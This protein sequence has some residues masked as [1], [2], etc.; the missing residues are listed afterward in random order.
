VIEVDQ[1]AIATQQT[2]IITN[3]HKQDAQLRPEPNKNTFALDAERIWEVTTPA[4]WDTDPTWFWDIPQVAEGSYTSPI[5]ELG[6]AGLNGFAVYVNTQIRT[7][8][9]WGWGGTM[10]GL[11]SDQYVPPGPPDRYPPLWS[12]PGMSWAQMAK[13]EV[14]IDIALSQDGTTFGPFFNVSSGVELSGKAFKVKL[15]LKQNLPLVPVEV[16]KCIVTVC[17]PERV[18][19][20]DLPFIDDRCHEVEFTTPFYEIDSAV[21]TPQHSIITYIPYMSPAGLTVQTSNTYTGL[22]HLMVKGV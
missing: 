6:T 1:I 20:I 2:S 16:E 18:L 4:L 21:T 9:D 17:M 11:P 12:L 13:P 19:A 5:I 8:T 10:I 7:F 14:H 3:M 15:V 22:V